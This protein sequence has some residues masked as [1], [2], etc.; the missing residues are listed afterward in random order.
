MK[1]K[2]LCLLL[3]IFYASSCGNGKQENKVDLEEL[4]RGKLTE[5]FE[6][7]TVSYTVTKIV[8]GSQEQKKGILG[9]K[10]ILYALN[11][12]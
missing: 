8:K 11:A 9:K 1:R 10:N 12:T 2:I 4:T 7:G 6:L 3:V 5:L